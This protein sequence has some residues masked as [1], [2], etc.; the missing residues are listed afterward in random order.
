MRRISGLKSK[1]QLPN[2]TA[3]LAIH[4]QHWNS[5]WEYDG[6]LGAVG[7]DPEPLQYYARINFA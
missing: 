1:F 4:L 3:V 2:Y 5:V 6:D 7:T